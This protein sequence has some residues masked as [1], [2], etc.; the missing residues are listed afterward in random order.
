MVKTPHLNLVW[1][2]DLLGLPEIHTKLSASRHGRIV[3]LVVGLDRIVHVRDVLHQDGWKIVSI[4]SLQDED[5]FLVRAR[6]LSR[7]EEM[8][9]N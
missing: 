7:Q 4:V 1:G 9:K 2:N 6:K 8:K 5:G 3:D